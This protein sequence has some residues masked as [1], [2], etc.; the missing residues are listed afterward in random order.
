MEVICKPRGCGKTY[1][2]IMES[3][4]TGIPILTAYNSRYI[5]DQARYM[6]IKIH[7]PM[8]VQEYKFF[9]NNGSLLNSQDWKGKLL[10]DEVDGVLEQLL[11]THIETVTCTPDSMNK[12]EKFNMF[13]V[14]NRI[15]NCEFYINGNG[16]VFGNGVNISDKITDID[17][18][19]PN[20]I[21]EVTFADGKKEK[22]I[23]HEEDTFNLRNCLFIA[24]AKHLYKKDYTFEGIEW[25]AFELMHLKKYV[26]I[27]DSALKA[28]E[29]K[30]KDIAKLEENYKAEQQRV[31]R[32][33]TKRQAYKERRAAKREQEERDKQITIQKE[34]F[35]QAMKSMEYSK[36]NV[37]IK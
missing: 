21:V 18:I 4:R 5:A 14:D 10:I 27:V 26:K 12:K 28:F 15:H 23:C 34:A 36:N 33:R 7:Q 17:I 19:V 32:K 3:A 11:G 35:L 30:Q 13:E 8:S 6:G 25:K 31:E 1:D 22:M 9:K 24:I 16:I 37:V 2:L 20:K 29:K